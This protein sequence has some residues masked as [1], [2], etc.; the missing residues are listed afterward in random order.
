MDHILPVLKNMQWL[1]PP[2]RIKSK[3]LT[4]SY[5]TLRDRSGP[6]VVVWGPGLEVSA[7]TWA[8]EVENDCEGTP[9]T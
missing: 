2:F 6:R 5:K 9:S 1:T 4:R 8:E 7:P 3:L